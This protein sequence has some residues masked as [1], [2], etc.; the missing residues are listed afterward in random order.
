MRLGVA[1]AR[2]PVGEPVTF[3]DFADRIRAAVGHATEA[4]ARVVVLPEYLSLELAA[5]FDDGVR[6]DLLG[7]LAAIQVHREAWIDLFSG[8]ARET[9]AVVQAGSF[10]LA[11][12]SGRYRNRADLFTPAG[13][14][15]W[16]DKLQLTGFEKDTGVIEP[17][18][19]LKVFDLDGPSVGIAVCYDVEFPIQV[20]AQREAGARLILVPSCTDTETGAARVRVGCMARAL[21]NR[22]YVVRSVTAGAADWSPWL[23][24]NAGDAAIHGPIDAGWPD[25]GLIATATGDTLWA[26]A[27]LDLEALDSTRD[28]AEVGLDAD[29]PE[30]LRPELA[31]VHVYRD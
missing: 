3:G 30:Q 26:S 25:E 27:E 2:W 10:L 5:T 31:T 17:G 21:E 6:S 14:H 20:R 13:R 28:R 29:W 1:A 12:D 23:D 9:G 18:D 8:V 19:E 11:V 4:G 22:C 7:S 16:Q 24:L 15:H